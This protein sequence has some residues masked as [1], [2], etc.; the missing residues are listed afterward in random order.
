RVTLGQAY[1]GLAENAR[2]SPAESLAARNQ[3]IAVFRDLVTSAPHADETQRWL[4]LCLKR[5]GALYAG[6]LKDPAS[7][8]ADLVEAAAIDEARVKADPGNAVARLDLALGQS[9]RSV[10][11]R[12]MGDLD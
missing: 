8:R 6:Q 2:Q 5:R 4:S 9:Y 11:L 7:A 12:R 1:A 10:L 3:A